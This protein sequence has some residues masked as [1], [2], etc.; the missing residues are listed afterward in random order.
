MRFVDHPALRPLLM[1]ADPGERF[2]WLFLLGA[3]G[4]AAAY[5]VRTPAN[6]STARIF[7]WL[8]PVRLWKHPSAMLDA[9]LV[10]A[11][12]G[13]RT[14]LFFPWSMSAF[15]VALW[16]T[17]TLDRYLGLQTESTWPAPLITAVY[18]LALF[19]IWDLSRFALHWLMHAA[20][21]LWELHKVHHS[22]QVMTPLTLLRSHPV[23][24]L[25]GALRGIAVTGVVAGLFFHLFRG[26][27]DQAEL[28]GVNVLGGLFNLLGAN[29]RH[30]HVPLRWPRVVE[31]WFISPAQHQLHHGM[32]PEHHHRN[33]GS[34][35]SVWD[36]LLG[37]LAYSEDATPRRFGLPRR[38]LN[39][40]PHR[41]A[42]AWVAPLAAASK[43]LGFL[44]AARELARPFSSKR[45]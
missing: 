38:L 29:L 24:S 32:R 21:F 28:L 35:L 3:A 20:P 19:L 7:D 30:S 16:T 4:L 8:V 17:T 26:R 40:H 31:A 13:L 14:L 25:L 2:H 9:K 43:R 33:F 6:S 36:R 34:T 27:A 1:F 10:L 39:H 12:A 45:E 11:M 44:H 15:G 18:T 5:F 23:E 42:S 22:A 37:T 41:L